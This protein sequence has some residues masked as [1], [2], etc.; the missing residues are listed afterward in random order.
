MV[1]CIEGNSSEYFCNDSNN[2][3][4]YYINDYVE[5][6]NDWGHHILNDHCFANN[7]VIENYCEVIEAHYVEHNCTN[8]CLNGT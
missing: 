6:L 2:G 1:T 3:I 4:N 5:V 8:D 7:L